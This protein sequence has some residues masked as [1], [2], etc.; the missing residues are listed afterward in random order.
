[1][2][3]KVLSPFQAG[4]KEEAMRPICVVS[5]LAGVLLVANLVAHSHAAPRRGRNPDR[6]PVVVAE[7]VPHRAPAAVA[8]NVLKALPWKVTGYGKTIQDAEQ[9]ALEKAHKEVVDYLSTLNPPV[10]WQP[11]VDYVNRNLVKQRE[12]EGPEQRAIGPVYKMT[13]TVDVGSRQEDILKQ[14]RHHR[15]EMRQLLL[16]KVLGGLV[17]VLAVVALY[18]RL[19][20]YT[21]GYYTT[22]L[23]LIGLGLIALTGAG[24][25]WLW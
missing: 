7:N 24:V 10:E 9:D 6:A 11:S 20:E 15:M 17:V 19:E 12:E 4:Q 8:E 14:D 2:I 16:A 18:F 23:R 13:L 5:L 1:V 21:K 3:A 22:W 25:W